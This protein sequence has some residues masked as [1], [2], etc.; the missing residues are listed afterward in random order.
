MT[1]L[2]VIISLYLI[3]FSII[4]Y[5]TLSRYFLPKTV[6]ENQL[7]FLRKSWEQYYGRSFA[8]PKVGL[9]PRLMV[10][11]FAAVEKAINYLGI[12]SDLSAQLQRSGIQTDPPKF[13]AYQIGIA[14]AL[15]LLGYALSGLLASTV[16]VIF[17]IV[18][19]MI[20]IRYK[21]GKLQNLLDEQ[22]PELLTIVAGLLNAGYGFFQ[23]L[24]SAIKELNPPITYEFKKVMTDARLG[25]SLEQSLDS[26]AKRVES[27]DYNWLIVAIK[28]QRQTGG[29]LAEILE[30][31]AKTIKEREQLIRQMKTLTAEGRL[32]AY[33]LI[34]MPIV[35]GLILYIVNPG[36]ISVLFTSRTG[37]IMLA[38]AIMLIMIGSYWMK[39]IVD[40]E[41]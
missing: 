1:L 19:P 21:A 35:L 29:N 31:L 38:T 18:L 33:I 23:A 20:Y 7:D 13:F 34:A 28:I 22:L 2:I 41:V 5:L 6:L 24:D 14:A 8:R 36:Y 11:F 30:M 37:I 26:L 40:V 16:L 9:G 10:G 32:S 17:I 12:R 3:F 15:G 27:R 4:F 25:I 39:K